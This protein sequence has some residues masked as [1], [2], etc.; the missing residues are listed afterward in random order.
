MASALRGFF[1]KRFGEYNSDCAEHWCKEGYSRGWLDYKTEEQYDVSRPYECPK[2]YEGDWASGYS[3][4][5]RESK[6]YSEMGF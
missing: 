1:E 6:D 3:Q 5:W 4:G 2:M